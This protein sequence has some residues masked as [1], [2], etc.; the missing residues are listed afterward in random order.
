M[1]REGGPETPAPRIL[2]T[3]ALCGIAAFMLAGVALHWLR[4]DLD[5]VHVPLSFYLL[6]GEGRWLQAGYV[7]LALAIVLLA[8]GLYRALVPPA[9]SGAPVLLFALGACGLVVTA[10]APTGQAGLEPRLGN[11][12]HGVSAQTAFLGVTSAMLLQAWRLRADPHWRG[13]FAFA[14]ALALAAFAGVW[15]L[16]L[17]R[18]LPRGLSQKVLVAVIAAWLWTMAWWL[19]RDGASARVHRVP[20]I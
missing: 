1:R 17:W 9:R 18:D 12:L 10:F 20:P 15:L 3:A 8:A 6:Q 4:A 2:A 13:R 7:A 19:R 5:W 11:W 16:A 14:F